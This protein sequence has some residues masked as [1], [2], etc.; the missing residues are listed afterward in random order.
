MALAP[1]GEGCD[2]QRVPLSIGALRAG[3]VNLPEKALRFLL[4]HGLKAAIV[5][6]CLYPFRPLIQRRKERRIAGM[7][8]AQARF[9]E[10]YRSNYW[11]SRDSASGSGSSLHATIAVRRE[12]LR[13]IE[14]FQVRKLLDAPCGDMRWMS[15]VLEQTRVDYIGGDIVPGLVEQNRRVHGAA[16]RRFIQI[17]IARDRLP[18][19]DLM[20]CR[21]CLFHLSEAD[22]LSA[23]WNFARSSIPWLLTTTYKNPTNRPNVDIETGGFRHIDLFLP[24]FGLDRAVHAR[25]DD[26]NEPE[27]PREMCL[28]SREQIL[29]SLTRSASVVT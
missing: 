7:V 4:R 17:D 29:A 12:L 18:E 15:L 5:R 11:G 22:A 2:R 6:A 26:W 24:P 20:V 9:T 21:D 27:A 23:L 25:F 28:W 14:R 16:G 19:A 8:G 10:I 13:L 3:V 1:V